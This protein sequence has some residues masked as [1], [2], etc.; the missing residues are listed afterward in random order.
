M[1]LIFTSGSREGQEVALD[2]GRLTIGRDDNNDV[3][4][5]DDKVS[6]HH[7]EISSGNGGSPVLRDL[8]S[9]NGTFVDE[10]R[11]DEPRVLRGG[12]ELRIGAHHMRVEADEGAAGGPGSASRD[13]RSRRML[14]AAAVAGGLLVLL[15]LG[16]LFLPG[17]AENRLRSE[18]ERYGRVDRV[19]V[20]AF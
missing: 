9:R 6:R 13:P 8:G 17:L 18:L 15:L 11:L 20:E 5:T 16:Q 14:I 7:A 1:R 10:V 4:L 3:Q 12:E 2:D 19:H